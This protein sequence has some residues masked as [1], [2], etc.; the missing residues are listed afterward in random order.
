M[1]GDAKKNL[2]ES[3][4]MGRLPEVGD[5]VASNELAF[6]ENSD[7]IGKQF[8]FAERMRREEQGDIAGAKNFRS[9]ETP[10]FGG[11]N[12]VQAS[13][14]LIEKKDARLMQQ[15]PRQAEPLHGAGGKR[16]HLA[17]EGVAEMKKFGKLCNTDQC[18]FTREQ[19][20]LAEEKKVFAPREP[21]IKTMIG[22]GMITKASANFSGVLD[23]IV[24]LHTRAAA[25]GNEKSR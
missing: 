25:R 8:H 2:F 5:V 7:P 1:A 22:S 15:R 12:R 19:V 6:M 16:A 23:R 24:R 9:E 14:W 4:A 11:G 21:R 10:E 3:G 13:R 18:I 17:V 20:E